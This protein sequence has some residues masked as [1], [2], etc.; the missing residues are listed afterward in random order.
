[1]EYIPSPSTTP[2]KLNGSKLH[3]SKEFM[4]D[5]NKK[6]LERGELLNDKDTVRRLRYKAIHYYLIKRVCYKMGFCFPYLE[7]G[8]AKYVLSEMHERICDN[9][10]RA[11]SLVRNA[12]R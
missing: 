3:L 6:V 12:L 10:Y 9:H 8:Q 5:T 2:S 1:M 4:D 7:R 11:R